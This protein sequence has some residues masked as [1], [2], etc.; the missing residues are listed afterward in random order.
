MARHQSEPVEVLAL[1]TFDELHV[2]GCIHAETGD[3]PLPK[4][5][6]LSSNRAMG[7][8]GVDDLA[9]SGSERVKCGLLRPDVQ[10]CVPLQVHFAHVDENIHSTAPRK[11]VH[12]LE[13][14]GAQVVRIYEREVQPIRLQLLAYSRGSSDGVSWH[15]VHRRAQLAEPFDS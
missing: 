12:H 11:M 1:V 9:P 10:P 14:E 13:V 7:L 6:D 2:S 5:K 15:L 3:L 8:A 4:L